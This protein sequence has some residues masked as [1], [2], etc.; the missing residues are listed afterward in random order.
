MPVYITAKDM[1]ET[2][3]NNVT[4]NKSAVLNVLLKAIRSV[5]TVYDKMPILVDPILRNQKNFP[6]VKTFHLDKIFMFIKLL[7]SEPI[8]PATY[9]RAIGSSI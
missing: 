9:K 4:C 1:L 6:F 7:P 8:I 2:I 3:F 5:K